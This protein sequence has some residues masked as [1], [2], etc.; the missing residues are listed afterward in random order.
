[1]LQLGIV[2]TMCVDRAKRIRLCNLL[3]LWGIAIMAPWLAID[4]TGMQWSNVRWEASSLA[5][6]GAVLGLNALHLHRPA[7]LLLIA[8]ANAIVLAGALAYDLSSGGTLPFFGLVGLPLLLFGPGESFLLAVGAALPVLLFAASQTGAATR[9]FAIQAGPA[10]HWY[11]AANVASAF[12][13]GFVIPFFFYRSNHKAEAA[14]ERLG[15]EKL[16]RVI[17]SNLIGVVR[18]RLSGRIEDAND[19]FLSLLGYTRADLATGGLDL[20]AIA[21]LDGF[22]GGCAHAIAE[23]HERRVSAV[24]ERTFRRKDGSAVPVLVGVALLDERHEEQDEIVGFVLDLTA[25]KQSEAQKALLRESQEALRLRDLFN[26]IASHE[27]KTPLAAL[28]LNLH[29]LRRRLDRELPEKGAL[30]VQLE[31]CQNASSRMNDLIHALLDVAQFHEGRLKLTMRDMDVVEAVR[32][33]VSAFE[34]GRGGRPLP[35]RVRADGN[36]T[37]RLDSLRFDQ[38]LTNLLSNAVKYGA[39]K[40]IEVRVGCDHKTDVARLEVIDHGPGIEPG[41][42]ERIFEPFQRGVSPDE[43]IPGLGLGL[44]VVKTI[45][46]GHGGKINVESR[47]GHGSRFIVDLPCT[48]NGAAAAATAGPAHLQ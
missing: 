8:T 45:V 39:G 36:V 21:P 25:Q 19:T 2:R 4:L 7:R 23:L 41:L 1:L 48:G 29:L 16:K 26:S 47:V 9:W 44:Y 30:R 28:M 31:R 6:F 14:L 34:S 17:D 13:V 38:V 42:T 11:F 15:Q 24:Y 18:G 10:P 43:P 22:G 35:I 12:T 40:P 20:R 3:A 37:A 5:A 33:V 32:R 46:E 27:L